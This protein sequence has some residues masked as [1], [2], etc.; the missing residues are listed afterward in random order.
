MGPARP[1]GVVDLANLQT[2]VPSDQKCTLPTV[3]EQ[4]PRL[5]Q[6]TSMPAGLPL[7][8]AMQ[9]AQQEEP[10]HVWEC[11]ADTLLLSFVLTF[12][13][14]VMNGGAIACVDFAEERHAR[15]ILPQVP[16]KTKQRLQNRRMRV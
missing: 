15:E 8:G 3:S 11:V 14:F 2:L 9:L 4:A 13:L 6:H 5:A 16:K 1:C 10:K 7:P 12:S